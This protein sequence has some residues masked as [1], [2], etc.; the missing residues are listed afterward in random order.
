MD[1]SPFTDEVRASLVE[2]AN[3]TLKY[4]SEQCLVAL[5]AIND[6]IDDKARALQEYEDG[7]RKRRMEIDIRE[8]TSA[9]NECRRHNKNLS[10]IVKGWNRDESSLID[11]LGIELNVINELLISLMGISSALDRAYGSTPL[12]DLLIG[13][14]FERMTI[15]NRSL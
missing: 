5:V 9:M 8:Y 6:L 12:N 2:G 14:L 15:I 11:P 3:I 10:V 4:I 1:N 7:P 13:Q